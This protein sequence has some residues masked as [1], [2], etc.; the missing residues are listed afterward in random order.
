MNKFA[1]LFFIFGLFTP[2]I[3][4]AKHENFYFVKFLVKL[5]KKILIPTTRLWY[6]KIKKITVSRFVLIDERVFEIT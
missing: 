2:K 4:V 3:G 1:D 6:L 5:K